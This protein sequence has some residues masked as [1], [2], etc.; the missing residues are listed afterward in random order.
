VERDG[1]L[2]IRGAERIVENFDRRQA[3]DVLFQNSKRLGVRLESVN[4]RGGKFFA[5][6]KDRRS[7]VAA[8]IENDFGL[9]PFRQLIFSFAAAAEQDLVNRERIGCGGAIENLAAVQAQYRQRQSAYSGA[10]QRARV[11]HIHGELPRTRSGED[12]ENVTES[13]EHQ[14]C[15]VSCIIIAAVRSVAPLWRAR[16]ECAFATS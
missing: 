8:N 9:E 1:H 10:S 5:K 11:G 15:E 13:F 3:S 7:D 2:G 12:S 14:L 4:L 6:E 16:T